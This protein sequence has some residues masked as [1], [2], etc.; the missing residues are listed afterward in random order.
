[1]EISKKGYCIDSDILIDFLR[2]VEQAR[3]FLE[4]ESTHRTLYVSVASIVELYAGKQVWKIDKH[5]EVIDRLLK[6]FEVIELNSWRA[7]YAGLLR[8]KYQRPFA[9][10][11]VAACAL[12]NGLLL[13]TRNVKHFNMIEGKEGTLEIVRPY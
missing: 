8:S 4:R 2:G 6:N 5:T 10:M 12:D 13:A 1:M 7:K 11:I 9:D 3:E